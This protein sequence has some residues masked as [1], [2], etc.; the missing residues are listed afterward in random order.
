MHAKEGYQIGPCVHLK[1]YSKVL[2]VLVWG[3]SKIDITYFIVEEKHNIMRRLYLNLEKKREKHSIVDTVFYSWGLCVG[4]KYWGEENYSSSNYWVGIQFQTIPWTHANIINF[5]ELHVLV[6]M[7]AVACADRSRLS[8]VC[9]DSQVHVWRMRGGLDRPTM[10]TAPCH[11]TLSSG[12]FVSAFYTLQLQ[13]I[14]YTLPSLSKM[15]ASKRVTS[16]GLHICL[17]SPCV[18]H[19]SYFRHL[20]HPYLGHFQSL[21]T[22]LSHSSWPGAL[23]ILHPHRH[24]NDH[25]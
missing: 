16:S 22:G 21:M 12:E 6:S 2:L 10:A 19:L 1:F 14:F 20:V 13:N 4:I 8:F 24:C 15:G 18:R 7:L 5:S 11:C 17:L 9:V 3:R 25:L 23:S